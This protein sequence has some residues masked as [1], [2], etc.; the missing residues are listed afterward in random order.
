MS[1]ACDRKNPVTQYAMS[2][3]MSAE[4]ITALVV[5]AIPDAQ[6]EMEDLTGTSDHWLSPPESG[7]SVL[8]SGK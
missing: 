2:T 6:V 3:P 1:S 7:Y 5:A 8:P 4:E